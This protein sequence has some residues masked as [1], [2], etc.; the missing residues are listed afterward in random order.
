M[1]RLIARGTIDERILELQSKKRMLSS[2]LLNATP[3]DLNELDL[4]FL[5]GF[6]EYDS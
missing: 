5:L 4:K 2:A 1:K 3:T 6:G